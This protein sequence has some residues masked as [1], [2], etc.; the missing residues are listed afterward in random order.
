MPIESLLIFAA[1]LAVVAG[2]PGPSIAALISR[3]LQGGALSVLPFLAAMWIGEAIWL[4]AAILGISAIAETFH[5]I[6][7]IIKYCGIAYLL[8]LAWQ[9]WTADEKIEGGEGP[10]KTG[11]GWSMFFS[12]LALTI[13][14]PKIMVFYLALLPGI[15]DV[16]AIGFAAWAQLVAVLFVVLAG[17]DLAWVGLAAG[18][19]G[20]FKSKAGVRI[21]NR[22][23]ATA[24]AGAAGAIALRD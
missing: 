20:L 16:T 11:S 1:A 10:P 7:V 19:R 24:M 15:V 9:M 17:L 13:G 18:A 3:V 22:L 2:S 12:G 21:A 5:G 4:T 23:S 6:F 8:Y 14:N